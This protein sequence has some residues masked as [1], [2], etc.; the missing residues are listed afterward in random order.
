MDLLDLTEQ[1]EIG[2]QLLAQLARALEL[3]WD[4]FFDF[5]RFLDLGIFACSDV[6]IFVWENHPD[7]KV[8]KLRASGVPLG[9]FLK[10]FDN[11]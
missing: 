7:N 11:F 9:D 2:F 6:P 1:Y 5:F 3:I 8:A 10:M 4:R